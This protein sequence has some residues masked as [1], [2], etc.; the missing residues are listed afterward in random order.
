MSPD[1]LIEMLHSWVC[2]EWSTGKRGLIAIC[3]FGELLCLKLRTVILITH[4]NRM[5][6]NRSGMTGMQRT[7]DSCMLRNYRLSHWFS[8][9]YSV[10]LVKVGRV[11]LDMSS[12]WSSCS[13]VVKWRRTTFMLK[14]VWSDRPLILIWPLT[15]ILNICIVVVLIKDLLIWATEIYNQQDKL[16]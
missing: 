13:S 11:L 3:I 15:G 8:T 10:R 2:N 9:V 1:I 16:I 14:L 7:D 5:V 12:C 4:K 6:C